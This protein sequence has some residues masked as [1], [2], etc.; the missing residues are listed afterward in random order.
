[1]VTI[2]WRQRLETTATT[3]WTTGR[4]DMLDEVLSPDYIW[5]LTTAPE[6]FHREQ[7][8][9]IL[10]QI[11]EAL[12]D[13]AVQIDDFLQDGDRIAVRWSS[14]GTHQNHFF[15]VPPTGRVAT[16]SGALFAR[17]KGDIVIESWSTWDPRDM[18]HGLGII[19][20][21]TDYAT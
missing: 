21:G 13:M 11:R 19:F 18:L 5:Y 9:A 20:L 4:F 2:G 3:A 16:A 1:M 8:D 6:G 12:P 14:R 7:L 17:L 15:G 10:V